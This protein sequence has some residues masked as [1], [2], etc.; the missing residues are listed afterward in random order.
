MRPSPSFLASVDK[1]KIVSATT[2][3]QLIGDGDTL[4]TGGFVGTGFAE[5]LSVVECFE[6]V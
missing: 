3:V 6:T 1:K 5:E 4:A 2:A